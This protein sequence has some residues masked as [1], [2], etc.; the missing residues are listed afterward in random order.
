[1]EKKEILDNR[2]AKLRKHLAALSDYKGLIDKLAQ[3]AEIYRPDV[4]EKLP[5]QSR[6][7]FDAYLKRFA[8]L[9]DYLGARVFPLLMELSGIVAPRFTDV[10]IAV[11]RERLVDDL[12]QWIELRDIRNALEHDY[13][14]CLEKALRDLQQCVDSFDRLSKY[15]QNTFAFAQERLGA[16][17]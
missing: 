17:I 4:F 10:L 3:D 15:T 14:E 9:Q 6:A 11:E 1:M 13:P 2:L 12:Q 5:P 7:L 8:S 16:T